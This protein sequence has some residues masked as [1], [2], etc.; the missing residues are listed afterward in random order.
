[1]MYSRWPVPPPGAEGHTQPPQAGL[2]E[3]KKR[4]MHQ[5]TKSTSTHQEH[6]VVAAK[7]NRRGGHREYRLRM[8]QNWCKRWH[9]V[10]SL[11]PCFLLLSGSTPLREQVTLIPV[12]DL[13]HLSI[14]KKRFFHQEATET[15]TKNASIAP[16]QKRER[17]RKIQNPSIDA[18]RF[19]F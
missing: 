9:T 19:F 13:L 14:G 11:S 17:G 4:E 8:A 16:A 1:M 2:E 10:A 18:D 15:A 6:D 5:H 3:C 7:R 12:S